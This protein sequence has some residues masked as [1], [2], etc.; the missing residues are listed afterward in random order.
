MK[1]V[2]L[3]LFLVTLSVGYVVSNVQILKSERGETNPAPMSLGLRRQSD[4]VIV[5]VLDGVPV[6]V[7]YNDNVMPFLVEL[8][9]KG[10]HGVLRAPEETTTPAGVCALATGQNT[11][12]ADMLDMFCATEY[13]GWT[14]FDDIVRRGETFSLGGDKAWT[15]LL[16]S[17]DPDGVRV[18]DTETRLYQDARQVLNNA[19]VRRESDKPPSLTVVHVSETD[20][21]G[22]LYGTENREYK[23]RMREIDGELRAFVKRVVTENATLIITADHGNDVYGSHGG[24]EDIYRNVPIIMTGRGIRQGAEIR[25][26]ARALP[27]MLAVLLGTRVPA[28]MQAV[29]PVEAF[30]LTESERAT[31]VKANAVQ[32]ERLAAVQGLKLPASVSGELQ[33]I[34]EFATEG[35]SKEAVSAGPKILSYVVSALDAASPLGVAR[36]LWAFVLFCALLIVAI[37][38]LWPVRDLTTTY[39]IALWTITGTFVVEW[40]CASSA[41]HTIPPSVA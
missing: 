18:T 35:Q 14:I 40:T 11:S 33:R 36:I 22:H 21:I 29:I 39:A 17:R 31:L 3:P 1:R 16:A 28:G 5:V 34:E 2:I 27:G 12:A 10:S 6:R 26:D 38:V 23:K 41:S 8:S 25:M 24:E 30:A 15:S 20:R 32:L 9:R 7:G 4:R 13:N 37:E 19:A